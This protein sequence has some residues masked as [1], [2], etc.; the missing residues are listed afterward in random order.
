MHS[1]AATTAGSRGKTEAGGGGDAGE[2]EQE[3]EELG[4]RS[5]SSE[6]HFDEKPVEVI[7]SLSL[8]L[9]LPMYSPRPSRVRRWPPRSPEC[10]AAPESKTTPASLEL[11]GPS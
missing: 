11:Y 10:N 8:S 1:D 7:L 9:S 6:D 2:R 5:N 3:E 4:N